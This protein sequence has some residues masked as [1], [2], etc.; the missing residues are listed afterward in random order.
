MISHPQRG[1]SLLEGLI[2]LAI[3]GFAILIAAAFLN[4]QTIAAERLQ[5]QSELVRQIEAVIEGLRAGTIPL[6]S[7][8]APTMLQSNEVEELAVSLQVIPQDPPGLFEITVRAGCRSRH[9]PL[10]RSITTLVWRPQ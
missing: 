7:S 5:A 6:R 10:T 1:A 4:T 2:A 9:G 3:L 8:E